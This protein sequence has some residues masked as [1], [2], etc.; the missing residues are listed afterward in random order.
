MAFLCSRMGKKSYLYLLTSSTRYQLHSSGAH[1]NVFHTMHHTWTFWKLAHWHPQTHWGCSH[2]VPFYT[3][4]LWPVVIRS[5]LTHSVSKQALPYTLPFAKIQ[6]PSFFFL[7]LSWHIS[8][9]VILKSRCVSP[10]E[11]TALHCSHITYPPPQWLVSIQV[12]DLNSM[13]S[14]LS[15]NN[16]GISRI[17]CS[18]VTFEQDKCFLTDKS[19]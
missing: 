6:K 16:L 17:F 12:Y 15:S 18:T 9:E 3:S 4:V 5:L 1:K 7:F 19:K 13:Q 8:D 11:Y 10:E 2:L 14:T